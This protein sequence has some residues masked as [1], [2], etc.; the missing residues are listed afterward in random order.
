VPAEHEVK[1][2][3]NDLA[4]AVAEV[5]G[6]GVV[7]LAQLGAELGDFF[8]RLDGIVLHATQQGGEAGLLREVTAGDEAALLLLVLLHGGEVQ[9]GGAEL[10][11]LGVFLEKLREVEALA[12][13]V[14][15]LVEVDGADAVLHLLEI[16]R[17]VDDV[18]V[19]AHVAEQA[20]ETALAK[21]HELLGQ[22]DAVE[23]GAVEIVADEGIPR[24][25]G[26]VFLHQGAATV[27]EVVD[28]VGRKQVLQLQAIDAGGV[29]GFDVEVVVVVI[30]LVHHT[31]T[32]GTGVAEFAVV[33]ALH[34]QMRH[35][36]EV[37]GAELR[38]DAGEL[39]INFLLQL[40][41]VEH[42]APVGGVAV[43]V[44]ERIAFGKTAQLVIRRRQRVAAAKLIKVGD[45]LIRDGDEVFALGDFVH[46]GG[47]V[48]ILRS[49]LQEGISHHGLRPCDTTPTCRACSPRSI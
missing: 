21:F 33:H 26:D 39:R 8:K 31:H 10:H 44:G 11:H 45:Q 48:R 13:L 3:L 9:A 24:H 7:I 35:G 38:V 34:K 42:A 32:E 49:R 17:H 29:G 28:A 2:A 15:L 47:C 1:V 16:G 25:T 27:H 12:P 4:H 43:L 46:A 36:F 18:I 23:V 19:A 20:N 6:V 37:P 40:T 22:A 30:V 41:R 14:A 5:E